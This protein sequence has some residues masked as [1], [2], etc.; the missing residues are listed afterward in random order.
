VSG[1]GRGFTGGGVVSITTAFEVEAPSTDFLVFLGWMI[2]CRFG[3]TGDDSVSVV[4]PVTAK[5]KIRQ[6]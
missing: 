3:L 4:V 6:I 2:S 5:F 1:F